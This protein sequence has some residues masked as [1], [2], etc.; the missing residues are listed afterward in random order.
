MKFRVIVAADADWGIGKDGS[1]PWRLPE[2]MARFKSLTASTQDAVR[3]NAVVMGRKTWD[4]LPGRFR[5]LPGRRNIVLTRNAFASIDGAVG[6]GS[7]EA[8]LRVAEDMGVEKIWVIGGAEI[9][10]SAL[11]HPECEGL[12]VTRLKERFACDVFF[13]ASLLAPFTCVVSEQPMSE[14]CRFETWERL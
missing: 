7:F 3:N 12:D 10:S 5:P 14:A 6:A 9:Y 4:S 2:D 13:D 1:I 8:A 11:Q